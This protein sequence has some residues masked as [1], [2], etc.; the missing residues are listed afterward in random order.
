MVGSRAAAAGGDFALSGT[1]ADKLDCD[2]RRVII[3]IHRNGIEGMG[4]RLPR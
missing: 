3:R 1:I 2:C 4:V